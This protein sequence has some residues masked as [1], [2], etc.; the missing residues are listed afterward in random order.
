MNFKNK[1]LSIIIP[2][3][4]DEI[5][6][7]GGTIAYYRDLGWEVNALVVSGHLPP[8]YTE[9]EFKI[10][11]EEYFHASKIVG[12]NTTE[13]LK[14]PATKIQDLPISELNTNLFNFVKKTDPS[15][16]LI[17]FPDR[18][19]DHRLIFEA[20]MVVSRP[21]NFGRT[22]NLV[23][24]YETLSETH[25]NAPYIEPNLIPNI[26]IDI[27]QTIDKKISALRCYKS[28]IDENQ[29]PR[30]VEAVK[31]LAKFRGSQS[32]YDFAESFVCIRLNIN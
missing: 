25:W 32:G 21:V 3:P 14:I 18:H 2:H 9:E 22:I 23:A 20:S 12:I 13:F 26:N 28:Q 4:D 19:I 17:P 8:L 31:S 15:I 5:L 7:A 10:T 1:K 29:S 24:A 27:S 16:L 11:K 6:G 30:S